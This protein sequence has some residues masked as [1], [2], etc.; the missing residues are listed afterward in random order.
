MK[1]KTLFFCGHNSP[2]GRAHLHAILNDFDLLAVIIAT[3]DRWSLFGEALRGKSYYPTKAGSSFLSEVKNFVKKKAPERI[4]QLIKKDYT[5]ETDVITILRKIKIPLWRVFDVNDTKF[6]AKIKTLKPDLIISAAYPQ[7]FSKELLSLPRKASV[8]F[9]P[10]L[11]PRYRGAHPHYW[12]LAQ[13]EQYGGVSAHF[14]TENVDDGDII[15]QIEFPIHEYNYSQ[16]YDRII[17][18]T[19]NI[20][21]KVEKYFTKGNHEGKKQD[22]SKAT[23]FRNDR[24]IHHRIFWR[25]HNSKEICNLVRAGGAFCFFRSKKLYIRKCYLSETNRNLTNNVQVEEGTIID[26]YKD[27]L[28][29]KTKDACISIQKVN[30]NDNVLTYLNFVK[31]YGI[32]IGEKLE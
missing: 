17:K 31:N 27:S 6:T 5:K 13:G 20:V 9:H 26:I 3:D 11:L 30:Y 29:V 4:V 32:E 22:S 25:L 1:I 12:A 2:Y 14:M 15:A 16:L 23:Y 7:I 18:E 28:V 8:N 21:N 24:V 19:P 10:S